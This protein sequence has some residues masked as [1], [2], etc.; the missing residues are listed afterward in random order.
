MEPP[1]GNPPPKG[2]EIRFKATLPFKF[3]DKPN[4][5]YRA[6]NLKGFFGF[7]PETIIVEK[8]PGRN[9]TIIVKAIM[10]PEA[11]EKENKLKEAIL[12][13]KPK[14]LRPGK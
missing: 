9:N 14:I 13:A 5:F 12:R 8:V 3:K 4:R 10:S 7:V 1:N 11:L 2:P 6:I